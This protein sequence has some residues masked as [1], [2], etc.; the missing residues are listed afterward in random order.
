MDGF[1][2]N[3]L[4]KGIQ[5]TVRALFGLIKKEASRSWYYTLLAF[6]AKPLFGTIRTT[7][8]Y[9]KSGGALLLG[10]Q[11]PVVV[12]HGS[13]QA[14]AIYHAIIFAHTTVQK[15]ILHRVNTRL[16]NLFSTGQAL[17]DQAISTHNQTSNSSRFE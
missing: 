15:N 5:G 12:A 6:F 7:T 10:V 2:G 3:V 4:L 14:E 16:E 17:P 13:S 1:V 8:D 11:K 9:Q